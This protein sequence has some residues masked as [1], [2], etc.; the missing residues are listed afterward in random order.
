MTTAINNLEHFIQRKKVRKVLIGFLCFC[1]IFLFQIF[2]YV[3]D[4]NILY[5]ISNSNRRYW[6][7]SF[8]YILYQDTDKAKF[9]EI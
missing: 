7:V 5:V 3:T 9:A 4:F 2:F 6:F 1:F 8:F